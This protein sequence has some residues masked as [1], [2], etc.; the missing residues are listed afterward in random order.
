MAVWLDSSMSIMKGDMAVWL[1]SSM[2][3]VCMAM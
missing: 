1:D 2:M 3:V